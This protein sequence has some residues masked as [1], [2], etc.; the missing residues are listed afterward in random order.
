MPLKILYQDPWL[1]AIYKPAGIHVH[2][3]PLSR[4]ETTVMQ[5]LRNQLDQWVYPVHRLDRGTAGVL[6]FGLD[7]QTSSRLGHTFQNRDIQ[8]TYLA[9]TR[10]WLPDEGTLETPVRAKEEKEHKSAFTGYRCLKKI[11]L[12]FAVGPYSSARYSLVSLHPKTGRRH[13]LRVQLSKANHPIVADRLYGDGRH[14]QFFLQHFHW[15]RILL[16]ATSLELAHPVTNEPLQLHT[17]LDIEAQRLFDQLG[18]Q[19]AC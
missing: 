2:P 19:S 12:P 14:N 10:G 15:K 7:S 9:L 16:F 4:H 8:K 17:G 11:E 3:T 13:Q 5:L 1:V 6:L 18:L